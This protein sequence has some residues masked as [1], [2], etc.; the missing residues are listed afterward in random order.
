LKNSPSTQPETPTKV[1]TKF[2]EK[3]TS[4]KKTKDI[5]IGNLE[6]EKE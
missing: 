5:E 1:I 2:F 3:F 6:K 4:D